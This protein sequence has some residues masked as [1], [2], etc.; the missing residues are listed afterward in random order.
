MSFDETLHIGE[1]NTI[2]L[3]IFDGSTPIT[4]AAPT[5]TVK[6]TTDMVVGDPTYAMTYNATTQ[7]YVGVFPASAAADLIEDGEYH[8]FIVAEDITL[9][10]ILVL[11]DYRGTE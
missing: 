5:F 10:R 9:R 4:S 1:P 6:T 8:V 11:A 7:D 2:R 3:A